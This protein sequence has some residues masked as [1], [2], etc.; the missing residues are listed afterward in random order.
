VK[1]TILAVAIYFVYSKLIEADMSGFKAALDNAGS[2]LGIGCVLLVVLLQFANY[3]LEML[4][5]RETLPREGREISK[6]TLLKGVYVGNSFAFVTPNRFGGFIGRFLVVNQVEKMV[7]ILS[8]FYGNFIQMC[9]TMLVGCL[10]VILSFK[11]GVVDVPGWMRSVEFQVFLVS[12]SLLFVWMIFNMKIVLKLI[13]KLQWKFLVDN[14]DKWAFIGGYKRKV[15]LKMLFWASIRYFVFCLQLFLIFT[16]FEVELSILD[17]L[18]FIGTLYLFTTFIPSVI[19]S[20][21]GTRE[22]IALLL[23]SG[24]NVDAQIVLSTLTLWLINMVLPAFVGWLLLLKIDP[25]KKI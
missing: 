9:V 20:N 8:T 5:W 4:K 23:L 24:L 14:R 16:L 22:A 1:L 21:V 12:A 7:V 18:I 3:G 19:A 10:A 13:D 11:T 15:S 17:F 25:N 2:I 6:L